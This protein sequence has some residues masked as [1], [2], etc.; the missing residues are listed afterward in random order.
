MLY[1]PNH[2]FP[3]VALNFVVYLSI[4]YTI[5]IK[6]IIVWCLRFRQPAHRLR[7]D[8]GAVMLWMEDSYGKDRV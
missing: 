7:L 2:R 6:Y 5:I 8:H 3:F 4:F 1:Q